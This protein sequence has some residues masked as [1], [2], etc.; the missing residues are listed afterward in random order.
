LIAVSKIAVCFCLAHS[1]PEGAESEKFAS[2]V[3]CVAT[4]QDLPVG[5]VAAKPHHR[6]FGLI[7]KK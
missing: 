4:W 7:L 3:F 1:A 6:I 5:F 2:D